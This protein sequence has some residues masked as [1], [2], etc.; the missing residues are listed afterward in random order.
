MPPSAHRPRERAMTVRNLAQMHRQQAERLGPRPALRFYRHG[1]YHDWAWERYA[2]E[3]R[4]VAAA[5]AE[6]GV[7]PGDRVG[8]LA[9]NSVDWLVADVGILAAAGVTVSPH[10]PLTARQ[11][12]YQFAHA[13]VVWA[14]VSSREQLD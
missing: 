6:V 7:R 10:A 8:I 11:V 1:L 4:A 9:E 2:A 13:D 14:F 5:L 3:A 12:H